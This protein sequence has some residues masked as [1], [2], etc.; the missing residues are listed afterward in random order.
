MKK[1]TGYFLNRPAALKSDL[2][3]GDSPLFPPAMGAMNVAPGHS[4]PRFHGG[5]LR[6]ESMMHVAFRFLLP[7]E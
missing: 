4:R 7:Q 2:Q 5:R 6:R 3:K 1:G